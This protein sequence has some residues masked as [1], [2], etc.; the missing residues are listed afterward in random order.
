MNEEPLYK[1]SQ[2]EIYASHLTTREHCIFLS[3]IIS[4][5][6]EDERSQF[7]PNW[8][9]LSCWYYV[10]LKLILKTAPKPTVLTAALSNV[11]GSCSLFGSRDSAETAAMRSEANAEARKAQTDIMQILSAA[12]ANVRKL[13][14]S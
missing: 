5:S 14:P 9:T 3:D 1:N 2:I 6:L 8:T 10:R 11:M 4:F 13:N 7:K 12:I